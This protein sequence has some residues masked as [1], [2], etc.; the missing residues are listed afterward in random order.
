MDSFSF[1]KKRKIYII[2]ADAL[3]DHPAGTTHGATSTIMSAP[4]YVKSSQKFH[5]IL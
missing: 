2:Q 4:K 3:P 1:K 5:I